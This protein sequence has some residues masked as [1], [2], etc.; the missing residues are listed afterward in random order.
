MVCSEVREALDKLERVEAPRASAAC[1]DGEAIANT[2]LHVH[3]ARSHTTMTH[4]RRLSMACLA[5]L[6]CLLVGVP[7]SLA[8]PPTGEDSDGVQARPCRGDQLQ[9]KPFAIA[10]ATKVSA[11]AAHCA[12]C[13]TRPIMHDHCAP[14]PAWLQ[15][16]AGLSLR[17]R[18]HVRPHQVPRDSSKL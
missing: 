6:A 7:G 9:P 2:A 1:L 18:C 16:T 3:R 11:S 17:A 12:R 5:C 10:T 4:A 13:L 15:G 14:A 8:L